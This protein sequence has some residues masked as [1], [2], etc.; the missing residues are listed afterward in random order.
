MGRAL[1]FLADALAATRALVELIDVVA[2]RRQSGV[3][4][5]Q[6]PVAADAAPTSVVVAPVDGPQGEP[7][8]EPG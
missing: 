2:R 8:R 3:D 4:R 6:P 1:G 7:L 5:G